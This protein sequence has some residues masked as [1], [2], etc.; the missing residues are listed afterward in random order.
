MRKASSCVATTSKSGLCKPV[1]ASVPSHPGQALAREEEGRHPTL[2]ARPTVL[3]VLS[4]GGFTFET[5]CI[6]QALKA[7]ADF[8][9]L[10]TEFGGV[11]GEHGIPMGA[12]HRVP[13]FQTVSKKSTSQSLYAFLSVFFKAIAV[14]R[15]NRVSSIIG[16]GCSHAVPMFLAGRVLGRKNVFIESITRVNDLSNTGKLVYRM[17]LAH[18]F[19]VQWPGLNGLYSRS[20]LG[21]VL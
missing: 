3:V 17:K 5:K 12:S 10:A 13:T 6:L 9:Y 19:I 2:E 4:G 11:P 15:R 8:V 1:S 14:I 20:A 21:T 7:D 16:V 18:L